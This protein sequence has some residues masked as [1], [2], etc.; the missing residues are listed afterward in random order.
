M[1]NS[2]KNI[3]ERLVRPICNSGRNVT[4][5]NWFMSVSLAQELF[6]KKLTIV[7]T[8]KKMFEKKNKVVTLLCTMHHTDDFDS[9][10]GEKTK[11][12]LLTF[13]NHT[14]R[15]V[16]TVDELKESYSV[17]RNSCRWLMTIF[18][19]L[20]N[21]GGINSCI[22]LQINTKKKMSRLNFLK[23]LSKELCMDYMKQ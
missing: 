20:L 13:Y 16:D 6:G 15:G 11:S 12:E 23:E 8:L 22:I 14:K 10:T 21:I 17:S 2:G 18:Y 5:D 9:S 4:M 19:S 3:F 7:G 1:D